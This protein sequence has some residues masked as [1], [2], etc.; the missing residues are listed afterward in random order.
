MNL[1]REVGRCLGAIQ[2]EAAVDMQF[3]PAVLLLKMH[4]SGWGAPFSDMEDEAIREIA[5]IMGERWRRLRRSVP[6][7]H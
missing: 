6:D 3:E 7:H 1:F 4:L 2:A 5:A